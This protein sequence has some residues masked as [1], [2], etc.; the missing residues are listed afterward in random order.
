VH[1]FLNTPASC[2]VYTPAPLATA[3]VGALGDAPHFSWLEPCVGAGALLG[4]LNDYGVSRARIRG[5]D[6]EPSPGAHD[7]VACVLRPREFLKWAAETAE[8]FDRVI[9]N[10]PFVSLSQVSAD[11]K[12]AAR[13]HGPPDSGEISGQSNLWY[14][15]LCASLRVL[16]PGGSI[17]FVLPAAWEYA[18]YARPLREGLSRHF[19]KIETH[20]SSI[21]MFGA[22]RDGAVVLIAHT[23]GRPGKL[24]RYSHDSIDSLI[25]S[26]K[27][28]RNLYGARATETDQSTRRANGRSKQAVPQAV[29]APRAVER[30][31]GDYAV[32]PATRTHSRL[33]LG[34][35]VDIRLGAV[36]GQAKYFLLRELE[37]QH[38]KIPVRAC[39]PVVSR[40]RHLVGPVIDRQTWQALRDRGERV[41]LFRPPQ[42][43]VSHSRVRSYLRLTPEKGGCDRTRFKIANRTS[44]FLTPMP[45]KP[46]G[47]LS[48]MSSS[49]PWISFARMPALSA[50]NTLY[51][52]RFRT[53]DLDE[54]FAVALGLLTSDTREFVRKITRRYPDGL[55]KLEPSDLCM[56]PLPRIRK[57][58]IVGSAQ[59][60]YAEVIKL[61]LGGDTSEAVALADRWGGWA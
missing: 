36:T 8:R 20:R 5:L 9:A 28:H 4:A 61:L 11:V 44:W 39:R 3:L 38:L 32:T 26:L 24:R 55:C 30:A 6:F 46:D 27:R 17:G 25:E 40:A 37:R 23:Y 54:Q 14:A 33:H 10:P 45:L 47:F 18:G 51:V 31:P 41:W 60:H 58:S 22:I 34:Q 57:G 42:T 7:D 21:P 53:G 49:G 56:L 29:L 2:H 16:S 19:K 59:Q 13:R 48:G 12:F 35:M 15:F 1:P 52:V 43:V 50:T